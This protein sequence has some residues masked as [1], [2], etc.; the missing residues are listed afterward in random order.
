MVLA[1]SPS[2]G[3]AIEIH[4]AKNAGKKVILFA[5]KQYQLR[6]QLSSQIMLQKA[7]TNYLKY[8]II[9]IRPKIRIF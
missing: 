4:I 6:G 3:A 1:G 7:K 8:Y 9:W 2:Y 5:P